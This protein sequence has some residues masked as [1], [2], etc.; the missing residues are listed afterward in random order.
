MKTR[1][2][3]ENRNVISTKLRK[4]P[5]AQTV[6]KLNF[7]VT[8]IWQSSRERNLFG[9]QMDQPWQLFSLL[10]KAL[11]QVVEKNPQQK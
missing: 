8:H 7:L 4:E 9:R 5:R 3:L 11:Q 6:Q 2:F 10:R 1:A